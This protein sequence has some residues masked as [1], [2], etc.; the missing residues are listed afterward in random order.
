MH[1]VAPSGINHPRRRAVLC[2]LVQDYIRTRE[3]VSSKA[4]VSGYQLNV[5]SATVRNDLAALEDAGYI[6]QPHTSGGRVPTER[7][8]REF[9]NQI[10]QVRYLSGAQ[11]RAIQTFLTE[12]LGVEEVLQRTAQLLARLTHHAAVVQYPSITRQAL[13]H[14]EI[15]QLSP[16]RLLLVI[17]SEAGDVTQRTLDLPAPIAAE[18]VQNLRVALN[19]SLSGL[20][21]SHFAEQASDLGRDLS[22]AARPAADSIITELSTTLEPVYQEKLLVAGISNLARAGNELSS[23][24]SEIIEALEEHAALLRLFKESAA[25][26]H[27]HVSIGSEN[28]DQALAEVSVVASAYGSGQSGPHLGVIGPKRMDY[29]AAMSAVRTVASYLTKSLEI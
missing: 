11:R 13:R 26:G 16:T 15:V 9:V 5:S 21:P 25:P 27:V 19:A 14:I 2:A 18:D 23:G 28:H 29:P 4:L 20:E 22:A 7:G 17:I 6:Y 8:Y 1:E 12:P 10:S 24:L 3:P